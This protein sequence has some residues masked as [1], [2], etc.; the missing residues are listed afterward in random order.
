MQALEQRASMAGPM[1]PSPTAAG[2]LAMRR[3]GVSTHAESDSLPASTS[4]M[5]AAFALA[6]RGAKV[7]RK[8]SMEE[9]YSKRSQRGSRLGRQMVRGS[10]VAHA[11]APARLACP[12][13]I[14]ASP[15]PCPAP[16]SPA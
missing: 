5:A 13:H 16:A 3:S 8:R 11:A 10:L 7:S 6:G 1:P 2:P 14:H 9:P 15:T 12:G 4:G